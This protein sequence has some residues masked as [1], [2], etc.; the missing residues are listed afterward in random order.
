[1]LDE[2]RATFRPEFV[3]RVDEII[4]FQ[5]L[6]REQIA[7]ILDIQLRPLRERLADAPVALEADRRGAG[8]P[9]ERGV[10]PAYGARPLQAG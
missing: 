3:N 10:R 7:Q 6:G 1:M 9:G 2:V 5:P 8:V 4:V